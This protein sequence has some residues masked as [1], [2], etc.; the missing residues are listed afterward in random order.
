MNVHVPRSAE[1]LPVA[2]T[3]SKAVFFSLLYSGEEKQLG[4][5]TLLLFYYDCSESSPIGW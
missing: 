1:K 4:K 2:T 5:S 3:V